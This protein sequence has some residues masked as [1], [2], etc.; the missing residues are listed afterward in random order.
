MK[1]KVFW[2]AILGTV[3]VFIWQSIVFHQNQ[4]DEPVL[5]DATIEIHNE[6]EAP[7]LITYIDN[8]ANPRGLHAVYCEEEQAFLCADQPYHSNIDQ[9]TGRQVD[10]TL[11]TNNYHE[12]RQATL[13]LREEFDEGEFPSEF[14]LFFNDG[15]SINVEMDIIEKENPATLYE[16]DTSPSLIEQKIKE[17]LDGE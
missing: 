5:Y 10:Q 14:E 7:F 15:T 8:K 1:E 12:L 17:A 4:L 9:H 6:E 13:T 2:L 11:Y 16:G 3:L